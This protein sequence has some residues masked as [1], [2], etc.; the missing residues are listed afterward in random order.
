MNL[1]PKQYVQAL[2]QQQQQP[3][4]NSLQNV[5]ENKMD[6]HHIHTLPLLDQVRILMK[7]GK[8]KSHIYDSLLIRN[9]YSYV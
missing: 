4:A 1:E 3:R 7:R 5:P 6:L 2:F 9:T 8:K